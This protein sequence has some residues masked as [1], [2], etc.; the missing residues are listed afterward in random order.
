M[1]KLSQAATDQ[2]QNVLETSIKGTGVPGLVFCAVDKSGDYLT[3]QHAGTNGPISNQPLDQESVFWI[4]SCTK[5][6]TGIACLQLVEQRRLELDSSK[7]L[8]ELLPEVRDK[9]QVL[10]GKGQWEPRKGDITLR[11]LLAH[12]AGFGYTFFNTRIRDY[13]RPTGFQEPGGDFKDVRDSPLINQPGS[14][15]EYGVR[16]TKNAM[17][18]VMNK[19]DRY[20]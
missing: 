11:M 18:Y 9:Q 5:M 14:R 13:G 17:G 6:I 8:Y 20:C 10:V 19:A 15:W 3:Q 16:L 7:Q 2:I 12:T 1:P 4:A